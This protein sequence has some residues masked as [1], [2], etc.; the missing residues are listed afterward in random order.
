MGT[1][2]GKGTAVSTQ[3]KEDRKIKGWEDGE[4]F[5]T[6]RRAGQLEPKWRH[7]NK[8]KKQEPT[9]HEVTVSSR[10][11]REGDAN[12]PIVRRVCQEGL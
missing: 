7:I 12:R 4:K 1:H 10:P 6:M 3:R 11:P 2:K 8:S 5:N 9:T